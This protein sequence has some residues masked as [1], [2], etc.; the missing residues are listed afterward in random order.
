MT[1][2]CPLINTLEKLL[3]KALADKGIV[4]IPAFSL[5]RTQELIYELDR[6]G[7]MTRF[8]PTKSGS[9]PQT[10]SR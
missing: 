3:H 6:I 4:Y 7:D 9:C 10:V 1:L 2:S 5:G 8:S